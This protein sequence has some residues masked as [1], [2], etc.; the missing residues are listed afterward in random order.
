MLIRAHNLQGVKV[1]VEVARVFVLGWV[2]RN[3]SVTHLGPAE[4]ARLRLRLLGLAL[5]PV[6]DHRVQRAVRHLLFYVF[7]ATTPT[8][9][10]PS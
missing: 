8:T 3:F 1:Y 5:P 9:L 6:R 4:G 7:G 2:N 10:T